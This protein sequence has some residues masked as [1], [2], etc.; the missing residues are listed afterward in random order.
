M[1]N[2]GREYYGREC[3]LTVMGKMLANFGNITNSG[4]NLNVG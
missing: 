3:N 4:D 1:S 2:K